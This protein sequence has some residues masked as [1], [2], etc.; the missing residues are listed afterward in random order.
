MKQK[1]IF[2]YVGLY[3]MLKVFQK[4]ISLEVKIEWVEKTELKKNFF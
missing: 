1:L 3:V 4:W 2:E